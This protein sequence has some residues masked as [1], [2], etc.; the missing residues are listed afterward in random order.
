MISIN[1]HCMIG[2]FG[3]GHFGRSLSQYHEGEDQERKTV[4]SQSSKNK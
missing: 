2:H 4:G 3:I 1:Y